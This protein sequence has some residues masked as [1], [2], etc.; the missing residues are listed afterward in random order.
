MDFDFGNLVSAVVG[1]VVKVATAVVDFFSPI[2]DGGGIVGDIAGVA[3]GLAEAVLGAVP[4]AA[5]VNGDG[6]INADEAEELVKDVLKAMLGGFIVAFGSVSSNLNAEGKV[7]DV[8]ESKSDNAEIHEETQKP[9]RIHVG[10]SGDG[11]WGKV[12]DAWVSS[13]IYDGLASMA[14]WQYDN[15]KATDAINIASIF[16]VPRSPA[17]IS[18]LEKE[19]QVIENRS[20]KFAS[21]ESKIEKITKKVDKVVDKQP[22]TVEELINMMNKRENTNAS[23]A[24]GD[25]EAYLKAV[26]AGGSHM[27][28]ENGTSD[29]MLR[30][31][32]T[33]RWTAFHEWLHR[34][35]QQKNGEYTPG[36]D[37]KIEDFLERHKGM[38]KI[39]E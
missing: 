27:L 20:M 29:I 28:M 13:P 2:A 10:E 32:V 22:S 38:F 19:T 26:G 15:P 14:E 18:G 25:G 7:D 23:F 5:D 36:E 30:K 33:S 4:G 11:F 8:S 31:D 24:T 35:L 16:I 9:T 17:G 1:A 37:V 21:A 12:A 3:V 6:E 39:E 34:C